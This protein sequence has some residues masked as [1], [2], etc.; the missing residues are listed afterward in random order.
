MTIGT[1][2]GVASTDGG[3]E[4]IDG[5]AAE[6]FVRLR[7][8]D[9]DA[10]LWDAFCVWRNAH[11]DHAAAYDMTAI[12]WQDVGALAD[13]PAIIKARMGALTLTTAPR[14]QRRVWPAAVAA[15]LL[16]AVTALG[17]RLW[18]APAGDNAPASDTQMANA[19]PP[20]GA[21][22]VFEARYRTR[23]GEQGDFQLPDGSAIKLNTNS[24]LTVSFTPQG[25]RLRLLNGEALFHVARDAKRP[26]TVMAGNES[27]T[28][29]GTTFAVR[30]DGDAVRITLVEGKVRVNRAA[31][32]A[33]GTQ[34]ELRPG[35]QVLLPATQPF[36]ISRPRVDSAMSWSSGRLQFDSTPLTN[37]VDEI[38]RYTDRKL[39]I[40]APAVGDMRVS[41][42]LRIGS[43]DYFA[44]ALAAGF[45]VRLIDR[46]NGDIV[47]APATG[48]E[49]RQE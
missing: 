29:I 1:P 39:I 36:E 14:P 15:T 34:T 41:A 33:G 20:G 27:V 38:N 9:A 25:R 26:F 18:F 48:S 2:G 45:P 12:L 4:S 44:N 7:R 16:L 21:S 47:I 24:L 31:A 32:R 46:S 10:A 5:A 22:A 40:G 37:V 17:A 49:P 42:T 19:M 43:A 13:D 11:P 23:I 3:D 8:K 30:K 35:E 28:A 6:W